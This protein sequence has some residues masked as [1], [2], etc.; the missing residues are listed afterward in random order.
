[1]PIDLD[2]LWTVDRAA[3]HANVQPGTIRQWIHRGHLDVAQRD[4]RGRPLLRPVDV[5][6][7]EYR[8]R[9]RARRVIARTA[10]A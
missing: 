10:A 2:E 3:G 7:A 9:A 4:R 8:T 6:R 5:A 1:M